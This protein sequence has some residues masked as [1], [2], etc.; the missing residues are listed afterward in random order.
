M[1]TTG[2]SE[3]A[4]N[5]SKASVPWKL[6]AEDPD[7][8]FDKHYLPDGVQLMDISKMKADALQS[9]Y[10]KWLQCQENGDDAFVFKHVHEAALRSDGGRKKRKATNHDEEGEDDDDHASHGHPPKKK[11]ALSLRHVSHSCLPQS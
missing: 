1:L 10:R 3:Q 9:C 7:K 8:F 5:N 2:A 6:L 4:A 11:S